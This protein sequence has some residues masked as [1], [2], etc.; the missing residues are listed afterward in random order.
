MFQGN[1]E[2]SKAEMQVASLLDSQL[3]NELLIAVV[4][5]VTSLTKMGVKAFCFEK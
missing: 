5:Y 3:H 2:E 1:L 4:H